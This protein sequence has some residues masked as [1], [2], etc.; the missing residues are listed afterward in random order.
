MNPDSVRATGTQVAFA[1]NIYQTV[2]TNNVD[3]AVAIAEHGI[4]SQAAVAAASGVNVLLDRSQ[5]AAV[6]LASGDGIQT[7][8][9]L[10]FAAGG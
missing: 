4:F 9:R 3:S 8:Y 7:D 1:S 10:T 2:A 6:N 5:F